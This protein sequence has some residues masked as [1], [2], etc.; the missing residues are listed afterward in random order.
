MSETIRAD[1]RSLAPLPIRAHPLVL[2]IALF[3][4]SETMFF[5][6]MFA[7]FFDLRANHAAWPPPSIHLDAV[8]PGCGT[9]LLLM[10]SVVMYFATKALEKRRIRAAR[11]WT[12]SAIV[13]AVGFCLLSVKDY[14][15]NLSQGI[16][17]QTNAFT[18]IYY[19]MT[20][21]HLLHVIVG[22]GV[23]GAMLLAMR[24]KAIRAYDR[25]GAE[26]MTYYWH[27]VFVVWIGIYTT[28]FLIGK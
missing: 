20:G 27:F 21:F 2:G 15:T 17:L 9:L 13:A 18:S 23:L 10:A 8:D 14:L 11:W 19:T 7:T 16:T 5:A 25:A 6:A 28:V 22:I 26:A 24:S 1:D 3:L 12:A 4:A